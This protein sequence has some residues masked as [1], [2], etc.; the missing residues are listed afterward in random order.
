MIIQR[1]FATKYFLL[2]CH[3]QNLAVLNLSSWWLIGSGYK[4]KNLRFSVH[5]RRF[6]IFG[7]S[8]LFEVFDLG[9]QNIIFFFKLNDIKGKFFDLLKEKGI[10]LT[11]ISRFAHYLFFTGDTRQMIVSIDE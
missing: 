5:K 2:Y 9:F 8:L 4:M 11:K 7:G 1:I 10:H 3:L 6:F